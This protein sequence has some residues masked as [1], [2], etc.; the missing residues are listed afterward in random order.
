M[1]TDS[2]QWA[3]WLA[4]MIGNSRLHWAL[5]QEDTLA[6]AWN[7]PHLS[8]NQ[9]EQLTAQRFAPSAWQGLAELSPA[10]TQ[11]I[12]SATSAEAIPL[13]LASVVPSQTQLWQPYL[14]VR[15]VQAHQLPITGLYPTMGCD[16]I[17]ALW[18][19]GQTYGW[20]VLVIDGGTALTFTTATAEQELLGGAIAPGLRLQFQALAQQ[21]AALPDAFESLPGD[22]AKSLPPRWATDTPTAIQSGILHIV[23]AGVQDYLQTWWAQ[24]S[25][26]AVVF[27][28]G[29]GE[30]L[31]RQVRSRF[32]SH[33]AQLHHNPDLIFNGIQAYRAWSQA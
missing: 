21:T 3:S 20:P 26:A 7:T 10:I 27:T 31:W 28:G 23:L 13:W 15:I 19:A 18:G 8:S 9:V 16:R 29:D 2:A 24:Y 25:D 6:A 11:A 30:W 14:A 5:F 33:H 32:P 1:A 22:A 12:Q 4:L 17:L